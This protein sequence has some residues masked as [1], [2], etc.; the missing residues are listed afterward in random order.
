MIYYFQNATPSS[1]ESMKIEE[2]QLDLYIE[3]IIEA[4]ASSLQDVVVRVSSSTKQSEKEFGNSSAS[5]WNVCGILT[6]S[7]GEVTPSESL[8]AVCEPEGGPPV[9][10]PS[11]EGSYCCFMSMLCCNNYVQPWLL[12]AFCN[13]GGLVSQSV[14]S[15]PRIVTVLLQSLS[16]EEEFQFQLRNNWGLPSNQCPQSRR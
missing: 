14:L 5:S 9:H 1:R 4:A 8:T 11:Q 12:L 2:Q 13:P 10:A 15:I 3:R 7:Y 6:S 16:L